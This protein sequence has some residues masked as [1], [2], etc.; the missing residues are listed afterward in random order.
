M[1]NQEMIEKAITS[2]D[3]LAAAGK[4]NPEQAD[5]FIDLVV[6]VTGLSGVVRVARFRADQMEIDKIN[7]GKRVAVPKA[8]ATAPSVRR[9]V[10][11][12]KIALQPQNVTVPFEISNDFKLENIE[13][14]AV[15]D[16]IIRMMATQLANDLEELYLDGNTLGPAAFED[17]IY[18]DG[19]STKVVKDSYLALHDGWIKRGSQGHV[20]DANLV[21]INSAIF[22]KMINAMPNKWKRVR[23]NMK[24]ITATDIEQNY[25]QTVSSRATAAGDVA[26]STTQNLTPFGIELVP[27]PLFSPTPKIVEHVT[28]NGTNWTSLLHKGIGDVIVTLTTLGGNPVTPIADDSGNGVEVDET[29]G[30]I[31]RGATSTLSDPVDVKVTYRSQGQVLLTEYRNLILGIGRDI[32]IKKDEDIYADVA[33]Y[34]IHVKIAVQIEETDAVVL[35]KNVGLG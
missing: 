31:R 35:A 10:K 6:D 3:A 21:N 7:V 8:E 33:Q 1:T 29:N 12:S 18:D 17:Q 26:L 16:T 19:D 22:S 30:R 9:G 4:L 11:T 20:V 28:L 25:R 13:G 2:A 27:V 32:T 14:E 34:A 24:F 5:K 15:E 23:R